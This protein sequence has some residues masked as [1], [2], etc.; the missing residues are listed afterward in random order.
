MSYEGYCQYICKNGH[1]F[2]GIDIW[3]ARDAEVDVRCNICNAKWNF[4]NEVDKTNGEDFGYIC[5]QDWYRFL[6]TS[7]KIAICNYGHK[8]VLEYATYRIP[9]ESETYNI[10]TCILGWNDKIPVRVYL[11][12]NTIVTD[13][14]S[15]HYIYQEK[16]QKFYLYIILALFLICSYI[17]LIFYAR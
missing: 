12:T 4:I 9:D 3:Q 11:S 17:A 5:E 14:F 13:Y 10:R 6:V 2:D 16:N 15:K 1:R 8:H 7:E